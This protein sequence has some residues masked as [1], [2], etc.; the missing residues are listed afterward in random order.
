MERKA[1]PPAEIKILDEAKGEVEAVFSTMDVV[2]KDGDV[3]RPGA[4]GEQTVRISAYNH[5]SWQDELPI[6]K[7]GISEIGTK[8]VM[9]GNFFMDVPK[10][11]DTFMT[12]KHLGDLMEWSYGYDVEDKGQGTWPEGDPSGQ[13]VRFLRKLKVHE[14]SPV[15]LGAG[16]G[17]RTISAKDSKGA[18][19]YQ[20]TGTT[21]VNW[22]AGLMMRR[23][24]TTQPSLRSMCAWVDTSGDAGTKSSYKFPHHMVSENGAVG[25]A[26]IRACSAGIAVL[27]GGRGGANIPDSDR[28]GVYN[29]L[30]HHIKDAGNDPP[31]LKSYD[32]IEE[33]FNTG[34]PKLFDHVAW[35]QAEMEVV[36]KRI[37]D[38]AAQRAEDGRTLSDPTQDMVKMLLSSS[39]RVREALAIEPRNNPQQMQLL[40]QIRRDSEALLYLTGGYDAD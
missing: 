25:A 4:F 36:C 23:C 17:T 10:A 1:G 14:V 27:N 2:D 11:R 29:H 21:N 6:G 5:R 18:I 26:N 7:G 34:L 35:V 12:I 31:P 39:E 33:M 20:Q 13:T 8:G 24:N 15:L 32:E 28:Q 30:A 9:R 40:Q 37:A 19:P 22:D 3:T 16:E 38:A